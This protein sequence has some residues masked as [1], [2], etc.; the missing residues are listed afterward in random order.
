[1]ARLPASASV[2]SRF[3]TEGEV[4]QKALFCDDGNSLP[5]ILATSARASVLLLAP[6]ARV[7]LMA[8]RAFRDAQRLAD[9]V[10]LEEGVFLEPADGAGEELEQELLQAEGRSLAAGYWS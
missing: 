8:R 6:P 2:R 3:T 9:A 1:M 7:T 4:T 5:N 10:A